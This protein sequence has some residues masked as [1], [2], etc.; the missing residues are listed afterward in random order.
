VRSTGRVRQPGELAVIATAKELCAYVMV[1]TQSSP[2]RFRFTYVT[3]LHN[4]AL[5]II[6]SLFRANDVFVGSGAA[7]DASR[8]RLD[9]QH[10]A[11]TSTKILAYMAM[12]AKGTHRRLCGEEL[13][14]TL[15][16]HSH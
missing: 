6:E 15:V 11:L 7:A 9:L 16:G 2:A 5:D 14:G 10:Q 3:R 1:A 12:T 13:V 8:R 4:L